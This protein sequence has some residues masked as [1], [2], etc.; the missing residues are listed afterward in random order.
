M[1]LKYT[2]LGLVL[3]VSCHKGADNP[4]FP[5]NPRSFVAMQLK[6][7]NL[8]GL[9][10]PYYHFEYADTAHISR[11]DF[12]GGLRMYNINYDGNNISSMQSFGPNKDK[13]QYKY[14]KGALTGIDVFNVNG[15]V[16]RRC[17]FTYNSNYQLQKMEWE[18]KPDNADFGKEETLDF[19]Y[20]A[21]G[22]LE[23]IVTHYY[24]IGVQTEA[25]VTD[26]YEN[27]DD[28]V[29]VDGFSQVHTSQFRHPVLLPDII[30]QVN[31]P[32]R[33]IH[34]GPGD[35]FKIDYTYTYDAANRPLVQTGDLVII[36]NGT[37]TG[38][39]YAL[40]TN[41]SYYN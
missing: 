19:T 18:F 12:S 27:Y 26:R 4:V 29:N 20:Y 1:N 40:Q 39:H 7:I 38:Q 9:P 31:N 35:N 13:L 33:L 14:D 21:D 41:F 36:V 30:L 32:R 3:F 6:D 2:L 28:K 5:H 17:F 10:S 15:M 25:T 24:A 22:N 11:L 34:T 37:E 23:Q 16:Y 8:S